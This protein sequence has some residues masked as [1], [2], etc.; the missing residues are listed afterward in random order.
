MQPTPLAA[1]TPMVH[2]PIAARCAV[3]NM[4]P[5]TTPAVA[6]RNPTPEGIQN[7]CRDGVMR[8]SRIPVFRA[9]HE[10]PLPDQAAA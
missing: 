2:R 1:A 5:A 3:P 10:R 4:S 8:V 7:A 9:C 6:I